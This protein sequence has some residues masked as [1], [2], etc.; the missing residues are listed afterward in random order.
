[1]ALFIF[2]V[3]SK[4]KFSII[5][6]AVNDRFFFEFLHVQMSHHQRVLYIVKNNAHNYKDFLCDLL[7]KRMSNLK[8]DFIVLL[9]KHLVS[10]RKRHDS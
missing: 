7:Y 2:R 8:I 5:I 10:G 1:M 6:Y 4:S 3:G 9:Q